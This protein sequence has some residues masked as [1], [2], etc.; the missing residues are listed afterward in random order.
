MTATPTRT[1]HRDAKPGPWAHCE[2]D[3]VL[4]PP[5]QRGQ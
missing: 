2:V 3:T 4:I 1:S 5:Q